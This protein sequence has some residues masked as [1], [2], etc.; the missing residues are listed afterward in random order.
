MCPRGRGSTFCAA[1]PP[2]GSHVRVQGKNARL[3]LNGT[4]VGKVIDA[5][6]SVHRMR[7]KPER[8]VKEVG[9]RMPA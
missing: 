1:L 6:V 4:A 5:M 7:S 8:H 3:L 9:A 2:Q